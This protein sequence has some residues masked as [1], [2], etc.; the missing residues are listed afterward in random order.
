MFMPFTL[1]KVLKDPLVGLLKTEFEI[2]VE[3]VM[4]KTFL[5]CDDGFPIAT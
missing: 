5:K 2:E 1:D 3:R 4:G